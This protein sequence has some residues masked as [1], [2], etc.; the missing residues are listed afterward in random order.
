MQYKKCHRTQNDLTFL[1][2][3]DDENLKKK[4]IFFKYEK[5]G[6]EYLSPK[7]KQESNSNLKG[8]N[9]IKE[10]SCVIAAK[11]CAYYV[12]TKISCT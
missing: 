12:K 1:I 9:R 4:H 7:E 8:N 3:E 2:N 11:K 10:S 6:R 5:T